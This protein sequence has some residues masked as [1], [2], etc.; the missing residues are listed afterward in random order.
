MGKNRYKAIVSSDWNE[1]LAPCGPFDY[2]SYAYPELK[3]VLTI[4]FKQYTG[5]QIPLSSAIARIQDMIPEPISPEQMDDYIDREFKVYT[6]VTEFM[7]WCL[8]KDI[9]FMLNTTGVIGYFQRIIEKKLIPAIQCLSAHPSVSYAPGRSNP[10]HI[11]EL[12]EVDDKCRN[13]E[14]AIRSMNITSSKIILMG[15]SGGDGPHFSWGSSNNAFLIGSMTKP[16]LKSY[17]RENNIAVDLQFGLS[18]DAGEKRRLEDE[19]TVDFR[20]LIPVVSKFAGIA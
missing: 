1:C 18:Y 9:L 16:S 11:L 15:D 17:C 8:S 3:D 5:N 20:E 2:L 14:R 7:E 10:K 13:T 4:I 12:F 19:M 6:G